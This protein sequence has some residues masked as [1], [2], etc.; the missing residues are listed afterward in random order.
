MSNKSF[1]ENKNMS[2]ALA[3]FAGYQGAMLDT[4]PTN[5]EEVNALQ[6]ACGGGVG[7]TWADT[8]PSWEDVQAKKA[9]LDAED[10]AK[11]DLKASAKAKLISGEALTE[12][13]ANTIVL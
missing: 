10:Q 7:S 13:E 3:S 4:F 11:V 1:E 9:E 12:A 5:Q 6:N 2:K 8:P